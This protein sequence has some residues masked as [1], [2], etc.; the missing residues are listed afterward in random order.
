MVL[1]KTGS[2]PNSS[3]TT[4]D[5]NSLVTVDIIDTRSRFADN[6]V[7]GVFPAGE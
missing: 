3:Y 2:P 6:C 5:H 7:V 4:I 1:K